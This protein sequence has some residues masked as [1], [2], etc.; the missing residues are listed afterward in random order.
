MT[1]TEQTALIKT[2]TDIIRAVG[3]AFNVPPTAILSHHRPPHLA[4]ARLVAMALTRELTYHTLADI[5]TCFANRNHST[6]IHAVKRLP[7]IQQD[8]RYAPLVQLIRTNLVFLKPLSN[9][10]ISELSF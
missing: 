1:P 9:C 5:G 10:L 3:S 8:P 2:V 4:T 6:I 7:Q